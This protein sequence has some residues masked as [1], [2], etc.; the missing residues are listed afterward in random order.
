MDQKH[1]WRWISG[2]KKLYNINSPRCLDDGEFAIAEISYCTVSNDQQLTV[3]EVHYP[4]TSPTTSPIT[5]PTISSSIAPKVLLTISSTTSP[6][7][8]PTISQTIYPTVSPAS[9]YIKESDV[10]CW[11][12]C[13][14]QDDL[15]EEICG[16]NGYCFQANWGDCTGGIV[17]FSFNDHHSCIIY[18]LFN[19]QFIPSECME[20]TYFTIKHRS[21][22]WNCQL[23]GNVP[24]VTSLNAGVADIGFHIPNDHELHIIIWLIQTD[25]AYFDVGLGMT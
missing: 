1:N 2:D 24:I 7:S 17:A 11:N 16:D 19:L 13:D 23:P 14:S 15:C 4:T 10:H 18:Y 22:D 12:V 25:F 20:T 6:L 21:G 9:E 5:S 8:V 3:A